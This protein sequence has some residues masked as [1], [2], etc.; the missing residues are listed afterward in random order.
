MIKIRIKEACPALERLFL[1]KKRE[2]R[3][4]DAS[5]KQNFEQFQDQLSKIDKFRDVVFVIFIEHSWRISRSKYVDKIKAR[6]FHDNYLSHFGVKLLKV[7]PG[8]ECRVVILQPLFSEFIH[9][10][11]FGE[12]PTRV[13]NSVPVQSIP[14]PELVQWR[15]PD[16]S[17]S[18]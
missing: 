6:D 5:C 16:P 12:H 7:S 17:V 3:V 1:G 9:N 10:Y 2:L 18:N 4:I 13:S 8:Y 14:S 15:M 11:A